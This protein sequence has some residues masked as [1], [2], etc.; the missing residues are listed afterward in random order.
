LPAGL[1]TFAVA[2]AVLADP[3]D[4]AD[5][6]LT[7]TAAATEFLL[8]APDGGEGMATALVF[9]TPGEG[10]DRL[11][12]TARFDSLEPR[13]VVFFPLAVLTMRVSPLSQ[14]ST[15]VKKQLAENL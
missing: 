8:L 9:D 15:K 13:T 11:W 6:L 2:F 14:M 4:P 12:A 7:A 3:A 10:T 1:T 5:P